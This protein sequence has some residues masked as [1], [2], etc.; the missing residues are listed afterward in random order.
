MTRKSIL[1]IASFAVVRLYAQNP[2]SKTVPIVADYVSENSRALADGNSIKNSQVGR[3][4]RDSAGRTRSETGAK[5]V[6]SNP[7]SQATYIL[8][9][10][11]KTVMK[12]DHSQL[13]ATTADR[14]SITV[15]ARLTPSPA[16]GV[17]QTD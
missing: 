4:F 10:A 3:Y 6:I 8:D 14:G 12:V 15:E 11:Q 9:T 7:V 1:I 5:V 13:G 16:G 17:V 2:Q